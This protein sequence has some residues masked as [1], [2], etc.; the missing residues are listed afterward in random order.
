[1]PAPTPEVFDRLRALAAI[2]D[3]SDRPTKD[4]VEVFTGRPMATIPVGTVEDVEAAFEDA[5]TPAARGQGPAATSWT[6]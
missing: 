6:G 1:M 2:E 4:V 5:P 3:M